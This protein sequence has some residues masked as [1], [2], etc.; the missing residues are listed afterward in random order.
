MAESKFVNWGYSVSVDINNSAIF[1]DLL[2]ND[3]IYY[4]LFNE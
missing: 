3:K 2:R 1:Q 4:K